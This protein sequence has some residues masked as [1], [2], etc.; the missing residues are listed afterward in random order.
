MIGCIADDGAFIGIIAEYVLLLPVEADEREVFVPR[1]P[2]ALELGIDL[3]LDGLLPVFKG[4]ERIVDAVAVQIA[5]GIDL[6][7]RS[8]GIGAENGKEH[9]RLITV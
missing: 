4:V 7:V 8:L 2:I 3:P 1:A 5:E 6:S 9:L